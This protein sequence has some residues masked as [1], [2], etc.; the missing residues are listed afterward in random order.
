M[1]QGQLFL[2]KVLFNFVLHAVATA[3]LLLGNGLMLGVKMALKLLYDTK[4]V[5]NHLLFHFQVFEE[6]FS[7]A[8]TLMLLSQCH[9]VYALLK[10]SRFQ[11]NGCFN[12]KFY[13]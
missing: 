8:Q 10:K 2:H 12:T 9:A 3:E 11:N 1:Q 6:L 5:L 4:Q 13:I 7:L